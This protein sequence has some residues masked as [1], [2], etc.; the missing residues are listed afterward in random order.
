MAKRKKNNNMK[1]MNTPGM[2]N[3][4]KRQNFHYMDSHGTTDFP[5]VKGEYTMLNYPGKREP[6]NLDSGRVRSDKLK[7]DRLPSESGVKGS[8]NTLPMLK[9]PRVQNSK[10]KKQ[11]NQNSDIIVKSS[12]NMRMK[13]HLELI[14]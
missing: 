5:S 7:T 1:A 10:T 9:R 4:G 13:T 11:K 3:S 8:Q 6:S 12:K 14:N 2:P